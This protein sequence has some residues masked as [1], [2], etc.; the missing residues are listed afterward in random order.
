MINSEYDALVTASPL[1]FGQQISLKEYQ[2]ARIHVLSRSFNPGHMACSAEAD[3][4][5]S[6]M[7]LA[8]MKSDWGIAS[9]KGLFREGCH[10]MVPILDTLNSHP[11]PNVVYDYDLKKQA[12]VI[13]AKS[14]IFGSGQTNWAD[15]FLG[16]W[17]I[18]G[19][20]ISIIL[21]L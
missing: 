17:G 20:F 11:H 2:A 3:N 8:T 4:Y 10:A 7:E 18:F 6:S 15:R 13:S 21:V 14:K 5:F 12:F 16:I 1:I 19:R 9:S